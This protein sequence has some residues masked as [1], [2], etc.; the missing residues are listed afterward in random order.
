[1]AHAQVGTLPVLG[2]GARVACQL[3]CHRFLLGFRDDV[4]LGECRCVFIA[5]ELFDFAHVFLHRGRPVRDQVVVPRSCRERREVRDLTEVHALAVDAGGA[6]QERRDEDEPVQVHAHV[7]LQVVGE[8]RAA[9][10]AVAFAEHVLGRTPAP[11][12]RHVTLDEL[13]DG[14]D[15]LVH[16][17][18]IGGL[19]VTE[20]LA[21]T[22]ADRI[23]HHD[24]GDV[25]RRIGIVDELRGRRGRI[26]AIVHHHAP[27]THDAH[28]QPDRRRAGAAV[29]RE[30][31]RPLRQV[32]HAVER[33]G[34]VA[35][36]RDRLVLRI[37]EDEPADGR[38]VLDRLAVDDRLMPRHG[39]GR[40]GLLRVRCR[41]RFFRRVSRR[42]V[43]APGRRRRDTEQDRQYQ[44][45][46]R[47]THQE[48]PGNS[49]ASNRT[50]APGVCQWP[51]A[52]QPRTRISSRT[53]MQTS[54][55]EPKAKTANRTTTLL[56]VDC[57]TE[58]RTRLPT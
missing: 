23:D 49:K 15:V 12:L 26:A 8:S 39:G 3:R 42:L 41:L 47:T 40:D 35:E 57:T 17:V 50:Q 38:G 52:R 9:H 1:M 48:S 27:W 14:L 58:C 2:A 36:A 44:G 16:A 28:V 43:L 21:E 51:G 20:R 10:A 19:R 32:L 55:S 13:C 5:R 4:S 6:V 29:E 24:V 46:N 54:S 30:R 56:I 34:G 37:L 25:E 22:G 33:V 11:V 31:D 18:E 7:R 53:A 45:S